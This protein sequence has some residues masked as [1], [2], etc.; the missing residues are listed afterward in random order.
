ML[1][2]GFRCER[3]LQHAAGVRESQW[4]PAGKVGETAE[5]KI[6]GK[7]TTVGAAV[8]LGEMPVE[9]RGMPVERQ[10]TAWSPEEGWCNLLVGMARD[11]AE[12]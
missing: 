9:L 12:Q 10:E 1:I 5:E 2:V 8:E 7:C 4:N 11:R 3:K 6:V